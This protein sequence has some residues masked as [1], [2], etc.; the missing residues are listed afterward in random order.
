M[1]IK[2]LSKMQ[3]TFSTYFERACATHNF[4]IKCCTRD[5]GEAAIFRDF[6]QT[7]QSHGIHIYILLQVYLRQGTCFIMFV[8]SSAPQ[9]FGYT[10]KCLACG[11]LVN[12]LHNMM[13]HYTIKNF[14]SG[15]QI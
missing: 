6:I 8:P 9:I 10:Q 5:W 1:R 7:Y 14:S 4:I 3:A 15:K 13:Q 2:T 12:G 11:G